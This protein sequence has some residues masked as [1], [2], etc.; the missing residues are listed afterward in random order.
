MRY[1]FLGQIL[2]GIIIGGMLFSETFGS[3]LLRLEGVA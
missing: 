2:A 3:R 1:E